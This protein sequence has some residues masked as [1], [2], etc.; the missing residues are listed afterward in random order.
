[1]IIF[2]RVTF[3]V[4][5]QTRWDVFKSL[6]AS[7]IWG[8]V[9]QQW[10]FGLAEDPRR[11]SATCRE[12]VPPY[13][14]AHLNIIT[15][16]LRYASSKLS[17]GI[18]ERKQR[19]Q[20]FFFIMD[21]NVCYSNCRLKPFHFLRNLCCLLKPCVW[22][23]IGGERNLHFLETHSW[24]DESSAGVA[25]CWQESDS[26]PL[27]CNLVKIKPCATEKVQYSFPPSSSS[28]SPWS[29]EKLNANWKWKKLKNAS[30]LFGIT[31]N[32]I[33]GKTPLWRWIVTMDSELVSRDIPAQRDTEQR[34]PK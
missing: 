14:I 7:V 8:W 20:L 12:S 27:E 34:S 2:T 18:A 23:G 3:S 21:A 10:W 17:V 28:P 5:F 25:Q 19:A 26:Q 33:L 6:P 24:W 31:L 32:S 11:T 4:G 29:D 13:I 1:M 15:K 16:A 22:D 30:Q 9:V